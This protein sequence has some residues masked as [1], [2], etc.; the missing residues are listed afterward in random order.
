MSQTTLDFRYPKNSFKIQ[1][2]GF[3]LCKFVS[4]DSQKYWT[5]LYKVSFEGYTMFCKFL[6][7]RKDENSF[8][9]KWLLFVPC[10]FSFC[11]VQNCRIFFFW[12][13]AL[14]RNLNF[15]NFHVSVETRFLFKIYGI[16]KIYLKLKSY[17]F[18]ANL[19]V[20]TFKSKNNTF[21]IK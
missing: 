20:W 14:W 6:R 2:F 5:S 21:W 15:P 18:F 7:L 16:R 17:D 1:Q 10:K 19:L 4:S 12:M 13:N 9:I 11:N 8:K 3:S